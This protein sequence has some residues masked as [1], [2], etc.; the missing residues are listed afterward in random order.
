MWDATVKN[1]HMNEH[2]LLTS[3]LT[4]S[5]R[6]CA[7]DRGN[8]VIIAS[9]YSRI[10][11]S[12]R[13]PTTIHF[14]VFNTRTCSCQLPCERFIGKTSQLQFGLPHNRLSDHRGRSRA[15]PERPHNVRLYKCSPEAKRQ[16]NLCGARV[17]EPTYTFRSRESS[18]VPSTGG[19]TT[20]VVAARSRRFPKHNSSCTQPPPPPPSLYAHPTPI[21]VSLHRLQSKDGFLLAVGTPLGGGRGHT[22]R[23]KTSI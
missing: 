14:L 12:P 2:V 23:S 21:R 11:R 19:R 18:A 9:S 8:D 7:I 4:D 6:T 22:T 17:V 3:M 20:H 16:L 13:I 15:H 5:S 10:K 1:P